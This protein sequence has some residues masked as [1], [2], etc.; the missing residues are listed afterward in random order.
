M[1]I[2]NVSGSALLGTFAVTFAATLW[3][4]MRMWRGTDHS[5]LPDIRNEQT[6]ILCECSL[7]WWD[8]MK[9]NVRIEQTNMTHAHVARYQP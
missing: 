3:T 5:A 7:E 9:T 4:H 2:A 8:V 6:N 1:R